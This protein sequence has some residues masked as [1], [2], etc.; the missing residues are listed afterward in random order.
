MAANGG[1]GG[2]KEISGEI[3]NVGK[4]SCVQICFSNIVEYHL[5]ELRALFPYV[6]K[7][8]SSLREKK[9]VC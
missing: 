7:K 3:I 6:K 5:S 8:L 1:G 9:L 2:E 4:N